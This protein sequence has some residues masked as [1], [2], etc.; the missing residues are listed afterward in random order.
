[1]YLEELMDLTII[2][3]LRITSLK[4]MSP[5]KTC[6]PDLGRNI[7]IYLTTLYAS[8]KRSRSLLLANILRKGV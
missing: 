8:N 1:M 5:V 7:L 6:I 4:M 2:V 3:K